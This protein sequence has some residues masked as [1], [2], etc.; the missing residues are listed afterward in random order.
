MSISNAIRERLESV[1]KAESATVYSIAKDCEV[2]YYTVARFISGERPDIR[3]STLDSLAN[4][5][6]A[7]IEFA[8]SKQEDEKPKKKK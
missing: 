3:A 6:N 8:E 2:S 7:R 1:I 5:L 4:Y